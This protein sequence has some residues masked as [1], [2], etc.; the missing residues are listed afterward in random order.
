MYACRYEYE[1]SLDNYP[2]HLK[3]VIKLQVREDMPSPRILQTHL[4]FYLLHPKLLD[5]SKVPKA[6]RHYK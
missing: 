6:N 1:T 4:P 3:E 5:T 2:P